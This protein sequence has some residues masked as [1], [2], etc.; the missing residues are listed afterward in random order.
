MSV[1]ASVVVIHKGMVQELQKKLTLDRKISSQQWSVFDS[2]PPR[3]VVTKFRLPDC[4]RVSNVAPLQAKMS[5]FAEDTLF[6]VFYSCTRD[7]RQQW[8]AQEL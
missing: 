2:E 8:A 6:Y 4:Y 5:S 3:P 1:V 7:L